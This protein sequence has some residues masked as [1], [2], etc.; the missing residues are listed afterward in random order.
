M[1]S[2]LKMMEELG[3]KNENNFF[4]KNARISGYIAGVVDCIEETIKEFPE[5]SLI[6]SLEIM[7]NVN[8]MIVHFYEGKIN[9]EA[10]IK[11]VHEYLS[12]MLP[13]NNILKLNDEFL[14]SEQEAEKIERVD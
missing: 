2:E 1:N 5:K 4:D 9:R 8:N 13:K 7:E 3:V 12:K 11:S 6:H 14:H 10:C